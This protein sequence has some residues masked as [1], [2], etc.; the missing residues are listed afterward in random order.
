M[1]DLAAVDAFAEQAHAGQT[2]AH[3]APYILHPR[4][5]RKLAEDLA[6]ACAVAPDTE[7]SAV[8]LLHDVIEDS[9]ATEQDL[10]SRFGTGVAEEVALLSKPTKRDGQARHERSAAYYAALEDAGDRVRLVKVADRIHNLSEL[11]R[12]EDTGRARRY[13][14]ET[15]HHVAPLATG[16]ADPALA[17]GLT[18]ALQDAILCAA[19]TCKVDPPTDFAV[20]REATPVGLY[21]LVNVDAQTD[22]NLAFAL[23]DD[24]LLG[25]AR[26][27]QLRAKGL[28]DATTLRLATHLASRVQEIGG[29][30]FMNDRADLARLC[31]AD[32]VHIGQDD[33]SVVQARS[34][35]DSDSLVGLST[36]DADQVG[37]IHG[38][39]WIALGPV[40]ASPTKSGHA[41]VVGVPR[42]AELCAKSSVPMIAIGGLTSPGRMAE[43]ARAGVRLA[44]VVS[45]VEKAED[46]VLFVRRLQVAFVAARAARAVTS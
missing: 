36:H 31:G 3:G 43:V 6:D 35:L 29:L 16:A 11:F 4:A 18:A 34:I 42:L 21:V 19:E 27:L 10:A 20:K 28:N 13:L 44:A 9:E 33:I 46:R 45:A 14:D 41:D 26:V 39:D 32:G 2:R 25:G 8:A 38:A 22:P 1:V 23:A 5:V 40:F 30:F 12:T 17:A 7:L 24:A 15:L 37:D